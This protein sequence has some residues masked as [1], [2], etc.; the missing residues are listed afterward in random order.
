V[1]FSARQSEESADA[2]LGGLRLET[3]YDSEG[4]LVD[5]DMGAYYTWLNMQAPVGS[6]R[7]FIPRVVR[8]PFGS[9]CDW[10]LVC[11]ATQ[12]AEVVDL[13]TLFPRM[14]GTLS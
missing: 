8:R 1:R 4:S 2:A 6:R 11:S 9:G 14:V 5:A 10:T 13:L 7:I 3:T 12:S